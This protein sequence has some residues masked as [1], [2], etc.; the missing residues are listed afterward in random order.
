MS[1]MTVRLAAPGVKVLQTPTLLPANIVKSQNIRWRGGLPEKIGGWQQYYAFVIQGITRE[2]WAWSDLDGVNHVAVGGTGGV[3]AITGNLQTVITPLFNTQQFAATSF[4]FTAGSSSVIVNAV[5]S[6]ATTYES[7]TLQTPLA[8]GGIVLYPGNFPITNVASPDQFTISIAPQ[9][10]VATGASIAIATF[11]TTADEANIT[12]TL[13]NHG[14]SVGSNFSVV[15]PTA[16]GGLTLTG[17]FQVLTVEANPTGNAAAA[18][19]TGSTFNLSVALSAVIPPGTLCASPAGLIGIVSSISGATVT[20]VE[21]NPLSAVASGALVTFASGTFTIAA[22]TQA[23]TTDTEPYGNLP[24]GDLQFQQWVVVTQQPNAGGWGVG[25][26]G[27][28]GPFNAANSYPIGAWVIESGTTY[29][30]NVAVSPGAFNP[31]QWTA[32]PAGK[33]LTAWGQSP[34]P[35]PITGVPLTATDW[36][37]ENWGSQLIIHPQDGPFFFWDPTSGIQSA[38][39]IV[40]APIAHGFFIAMPQQQI[41]AYGASVQGVQDPMLVAWCDNGNYNDWVASATNQA[42]TYRLTRGSKIIGGIQGP[43]QALLWTD[44]GLWLM[45]YIGYPLVWGFYEIARGC[46]LLAKKAVG[47][48]GQNVFW[49]S[50][51]GFWVY[52]GM[53]AQRLPCDVWDV[54]FKNLTSNMEWWGNIRCAANTGFDEVSWYFPSQASTTG[55]N[56]TQVKFNTVT[57]EWDYTLLP[58]NQL[59]TEWIDTNI[60]GHPFSAMN[61]GANNT[62]IMQHEMTANANQEAISWSLT[63][64]YF[65]LAEAQEFVFVDYCIPDFK[66]KRWQQPQTTSAIIQISFFVQDYPDDDLKPPV[67]IGPFFVTNETDALDIRCRGRYFSIQVAGNDLNSFMRLGGLKFRFAP[68]GRN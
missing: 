42:G 35:P 51:D 37:L 23:A 1:F 58:T 40:P 41:V 3:T 15:L 65:Q 67:L 8:G 50:R 4:T 21:A 39:P 12:V 56:D 57:G 32:V 5:G 44:V 36:D 14:L 45:Q 6:N 29:Q 22:Q 31:A 68:D 20:I 59:I 28:P 38:E 25:P 33:V 64:G 49:M 19:S 30:A 18:Y 7:I 52:A 43:L 24:S 16:V 11:A 48:V 34:A 60:F 26:W 55:E 9:V 63:T 10:A 66:W 53:G 46:G 62:L 47:V 17:F 2:M 27:G 54:I 13:P 61:N